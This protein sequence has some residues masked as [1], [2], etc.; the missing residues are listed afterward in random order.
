MLRREISSVPRPFLK[1]MGKVP[2]DDNL[3]DIVSQCPDLIW[4]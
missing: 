4:N 1:R 3:E 2:N